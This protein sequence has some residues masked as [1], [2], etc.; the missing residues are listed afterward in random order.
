LQG[1]ISP[2]FADL[3]DLLRSEGHRTLRVN[4]N[5]GDSRLWRGPAINYRGRLA[6][7]PRFIADLLKAENVTDLLLL[8]EQ[9]PHHRAAIAAAHR[10]GIRVTVFDYGYLRPDW[11]TC[12]P[13][14]MGPLSRFP[15]DMTAVRALA[16]ATP[17]PETNVSYVD[18]FSRQARAHMIY[19]FSS[20]A[21]GWLYPGYRSHQIYHPA[22]SY[23]GTGLRLLM[24]QRRSQAACRII[25]ALAGSGRPVFVFAMQMEVDYSIR[26]Y[27]RFQD[28]AGPLQLVLDS[29]LEHSPKDAVLVVKLHPLDPGLRL[30]K[31][32]LRRQ[33]VRRDPSAGDRVRFIDGGSLNDLLDMAR[34]AV[35]VNSTVGIAALQAGV[36]VVALGAAIYDMAGLTWQD[37]LD[38]FWTDATPPDPRNVADFI[39]ALT[40]TVQLRG[41]YYAEPGLS[42]AV[43]ATAARLSVE[44]QTRILAA[45]GPSRLACRH[46]KAPRA[47]IVDT[48]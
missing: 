6:R 21:M 8:G 27:S 17:L 32:W 41:V 5:F 25:E 40:G 33:T 45:L 38:T 19:D 20:S 26:A 23:A 4:L 47:T 7:W 35:M 22:L 9:R 10:L 48:L 15:H 14:G 18:D 2:F 39:R 29:F 36:P 30:W 1:P 43:K 28:M 11:I 3:A 31:G 24:R 34:G 16:H 37:G 44:Q 46:P 42:A 12:E 13:D